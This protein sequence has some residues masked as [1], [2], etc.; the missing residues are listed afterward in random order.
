MGKKG[1]LSPR[2][3]GQIKVLLENTEPTQ[4]QI[5]LMCVPPRAQGPRR[6]LGPPGPGGPPAPWAQARA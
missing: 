5:A 3:R 1:D 2:K 4:C 6:S